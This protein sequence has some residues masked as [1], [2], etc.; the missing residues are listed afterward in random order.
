MLKDNNITNPT[1]NQTNISEGY[2]TFSKPTTLTTTALIETQ[3][4]A[5]KDNN[6]KTG[7]SAFLLFFIR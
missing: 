6:I 3:L 2:M 1:N 7:F 5:G 4:I